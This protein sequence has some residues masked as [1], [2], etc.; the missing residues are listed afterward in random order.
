MRHIFLNHP[1][2]IKRNLLRLLKIVNYLIILAVF[3]LFGALTYLHYHTINLQKFIP[4]VEQVVS[5]ALEFDVKID[6]AEL[7]WG[8]LKYP[9]DLTIKGMGGTFEGKTLSKV[10]YVDVGFNPLY[11]LTGTILPNRIRITNPEI[12]LYMDDNGKF[13][14][15]ESKVKGNEAEE[16]LETIDDDV[17]KGDFK[18]DISDSINLLKSEKALRRFYINNGT[19]RFF[20]KNG[21]RIM[22][23]KDYNLAFKRHKLKGEKTLDA[24]VKLQT[25]SK[26][27]VPISLSTKWDKKDINAPI[28]MKI[29]KINFAKTRLV[30]QYPILNNINFPLSFDGVLSIDF[31]RIFNLKK[32]K[33]LINLVNKFDFNLYVNNGDLIID[34]E[35][36]NIYDIKEAKFQGSLYNSGNTLEI[37]SDDILFKSGTKIN[38]KSKFSGLEVLTNEKEK[39][40]SEFSALIEV[41]LKDTNIK[42]VAKYWPRK[43]APE[44]Y[45][46]VMKNITKAD[47]P[48]GYFKAKLDGYGDN[49]ISIDY[50]DAGFDLK[51]G[52]L[53]YLDNH[54]TPVEDTDATFKF[55]KKDLLITINSARTLSSKVLGGTIYVD[56][57]FAK[58]TNLKID[59]NI[60]VENVGEVME[61]LSSPALKIT[62]AS[63][64]DPKKFK[65]K[66]KGNLKIDIPFVPNKIVTQDDINVLVTGN[67]ENVSLDNYLINQLSVSNAKGKIK[68]DMNIMTLEI[69]DSLFYQAPMKLKAEVFLKEKNPKLT[70]IVGDVEISSR[71]L[72][73]FNAPYELFNGNIPSKFTLNLDKSGVGKID[74]NADFENVEINGKYIDLNKAKGIP[75]SLHTLIDISQFNWGDIKRITY[76]DKNENEIEANVRFYKNHKI[77]SINFDKILTPRSNITSIIIFKN[78]RIT[79]F[80]NG[81]SLDVSGIFKEYDTDELVKIGTTEGSYLKDK[82]IN[83]DTKIDNIW[84]N[85]TGCVNEGYLS[86]QFYKS[87]WQNGKASG[88]IGKN[89]VPAEAVFYPSQKIKDVYVLKIK[90][91]DAGEAL[92]MMR[93][94]NNINGGRLN[95]RARVN[96][97]YEFNGK[98]TV[99]DFEL[100]EQ[101][102][103]SNILRVASFE[104]LKDT[105]TGGAL[106]FSKAEIPFKIM[107]EEI[108]VND[109]LVQGSA[110]GI[111]LEGTLNRENNTVNFTGSLLPFYAVNSLIGKIPLLGKIIT[112]E[113]GGGIIGVSYFVNGDLKNPKIDTNSLTG[114]LPGGLRTLVRDMISSSENDKNQ[115][116]AEERIKEKNKIKN[117]KLKSKVTTK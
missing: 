41:G 54:P 101:P 91:T 80:I 79:I 87:F 24:S 83:I 11:F 48:Q 56:D 96:K 58:T 53:T 74:I 1:N 90:S 37:N 106:H 42:D 38:L 52:K 16:Q 5:K 78:K 104:G 100:T 35:S 60:N 26:D 7:T 32:Q 50:I 117:D 22:L 44:I 113:N 30:K 105:L 95:I 99:D 92:R 89:K 51:N 63:K 15:I 55:S 57:F 98:I 94:F 102:V 76:Y 112:G 93:Y 17:Y 66:M 116:E 68:A 115:K 59:L 111:T 70:K 36:N 45:D 114:L 65:G 75:G 67:F 8:D 47:I 21:K 20:D 31:D 3:T 12:N 103:I 86:A 29:G 2:F 9:I 46:W 84:V 33:S 107:N 27:I 109:A 18:K 108:S 19:I 28:N 49:D 110:L 81:E 64:I 14:F 39:S 97:N 43:P 71:A 40:L 62:Q 6:S 85:E 34:K 69:D 61:I 10:P 23:L 4:F 72:N 13:Y 25:S 77:R 88:I 73:E 82:I